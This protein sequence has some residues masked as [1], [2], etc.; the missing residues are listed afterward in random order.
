MGSARGVC[1]PSA[2]AALPVME[3]RRTLG[4]YQEAAKAGDLDALRGLDGDWDFKTSS[5]LQGNKDGVDVDGWA[6]FRMAAHG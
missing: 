5:R 2:S 4:V 3:W 1:P 6:S